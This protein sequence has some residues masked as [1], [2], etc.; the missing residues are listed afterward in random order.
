MRTTTHK[1]FGG[2][3][4]ELR[5]KPHGTLDAQMDTDGLPAFTDGE[6]HPIIGRSYYA[7]LDLLPP[8]HLDHGFYLFGEGDGG[9][10]V[11]FFEERGPAYFA[12]EMT[13][14]ESDECRERF[15]RRNSR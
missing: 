15:F 11:Y 9:R 4:A 14:D 10:L 2:F 5:A 1:T 3:L 13:Q 7:C 8:L 6:I 12:Y